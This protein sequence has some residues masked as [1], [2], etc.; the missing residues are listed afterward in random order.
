[1]SFENPEAFFLL[2]LLPIYCFLQRRKRRSLTQFSASQ[3]VAGLPVTL[4]QRILKVRPWARCIIMLL[5]ITGLARPREIIDTH[6]ESDEG[7]AIEFVID[8]SSSMAET[9]LFDGVKR[10]RL[11]VVKTVLQRF[12]LGDGKELKGRPHDLLGI[13]SFARYGD[14]ICPLARN[15]EA[16]ANLVESLQLASV[17]AEDGTAIGDA[18]LLAASRLHQAENDLQKQKE[19]TPTGTLELKSKVIILLTDGSNNAGKKSPEE[20]AT[21]AKEWGIKIYAI[22]LTNGN[23]SMW[24]PKIDEDLLNTL[25]KSTGGAYFSVSDAS[26][27]EQVYQTIDQLETS[28]VESPEYTKG[29]ETFQIWVLLAGLLLLA[30]QCLAVSWLRTGP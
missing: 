4:R 27:L 10:Q 24:G 22:G 19:I 17:R 12:I 13:I 6:F 1:M 25:S 16:V 18:L 15:V 2:I 7:I 28:V 23:R 26:Q 29:K 3:L 9:L 8:R 14:T 20:A 21:Q 5:I 30:D 11:E